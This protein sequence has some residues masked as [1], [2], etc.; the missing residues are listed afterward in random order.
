[1]AKRTKGFKLG[2][3]VVILVVL[4]ALASMPVKQTLSVGTGY[5][6]KRLC[7]EVYLAE[8]A[9][10]EVWRED[11]ALLPLFLLSYQM[12]DA[13]KVRAFV[14]NVIGERDELAAFLNWQWQPWEELTLNS[15]I[16]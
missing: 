14:Q 3:G 16:R 11:L 9:A 4:I 2:V 5:A 15:G 1:M 10:D 7:S 12:D 6:A 13:K 8:R